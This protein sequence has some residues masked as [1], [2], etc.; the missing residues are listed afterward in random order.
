M[1]FS[2][3]CALL[4]AGGLP[5][6]GPD[7]AFSQSSGN[8]FE[9]PMYCQYVTSY[10]QYCYFM[11]GVSS[12]TIDSSGD[13]AV[14]ALTEPETG[15]LI[16]V[17]QCASEG[18]G[19]CQ[20]PFQ[21][22]VSSTVST[23]IQ[24]YSMGA[25]ASSSDGEAQ[26][27]IP[28]PGNALYATDTGNWQE[29]SLHTAT[30]N[31]GGGAQGNTQAQVSY[32]PAVTLSSTMQLLLQPNTIGCPGPSCQNFPTFLMGIG[33]E[34][35]MLLGPPSSTLTYN[36]V[37]ESMSLLAN[38]CPSS[39]QQPCNATGGFMTGNDQSSY[40]TF[41]YQIPE[42]TYGNQFYDQHVLYGFTDVLGAANMSSCQI[43]CMHTYSSN[44]CPS[45]TEYL[46]IKWLDHST[47]GG[48][49]VTPVTVVSMSQ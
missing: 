35:V 5:F 28:P 10:A 13:L 26:L 42:L 11:I 37:S 18:G 6:L 48:T 33:T 30:F 29:Q 23:Q 15:F 44:G 25:V 22:Q 41:G 49:P 14:S 7:A 1:H 47:A 40:T 31:P 38:S 46:L 32:C 12:L 8:E 3:I 36:M 9:S 4:L 24:P 19:G 2:K 45:L 27:T 43:M 20:P 39:V 34:D 16:N 21:P 17:T